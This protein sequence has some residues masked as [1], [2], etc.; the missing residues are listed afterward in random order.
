MRSQL[1]GAWGLVEY[2]AHKERNTHDKV[3]PMGED[4]KGTIMFTPDGYMSAQLQ[5]L[6]T[7]KFQ[8][9]DL[10]SGP[11]EEW[12]AAGENSIAYTGPYFLDEDSEVAI[13]QHHVTNSI[14]PSWLHDIQRR[15]VNITEQGAVWLWGR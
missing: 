9:N 7:P 8:D 1:I 6:G 13:L 3:Y 11:K 14:L 5:K 12:Q 4:A 10:N 15:T 2:S